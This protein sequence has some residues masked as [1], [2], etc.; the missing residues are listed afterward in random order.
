MSPCRR[1]LPVLGALVATVMLAAS[2]GAGPA[3]AQ[4]RPLPPAPVPQPPAAPP[5]PSPMPMRPRA[6]QVMALSSPA[7]ADGGR[8]PDAHAQPGRDVSPPLAWS[9]APAGTQS[10]VLLVR[11]LDEIAPATGEAQLHW[12]VWTCR[13]RPRPCPRVCRKATPRS[14]HAGLACRRGRPIGCGR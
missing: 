11:D 10:F 1:R 14:R 2:V 7:W 8:I 4:P 9:G 12:L 6:V 5:P 3:A 13:A